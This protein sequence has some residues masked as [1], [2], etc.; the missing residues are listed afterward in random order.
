MVK[1]KVYELFS[2]ALQNEDSPKNHWYLQIKSDVQIYREN[3]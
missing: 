2:G 1:P 3:F